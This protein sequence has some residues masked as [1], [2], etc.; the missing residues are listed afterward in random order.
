MKLLELAHEVGI[1]VKK[2]SNGKGGE[3]HCACPSCGEGIDRFMIWP[4]INRYW[5]RRCDAN[6]D[7]IQFCRDFLN[8]TF[9]ESCQRVG[10][11][12]CTYE[13]PQVEH[14]I[15]ESFV[16]AQQPPKA[17]QEKA[18]AYVEWAHKQL[19][20]SLVTLNELHKRGFESQTISRYK[21]GHSINAD[22]SSGPDFFRERSKWGLPPEYRANGTSRKLWLPSGLVIPSFS[23][24]GSIYKLKVRRE[25]W[26]SQDQLPK[27]VE[28]SGSK[29]CPSFYG[30]ASCQVAI[31]L[32]AELD[33]M[34]IQQ[35]AGNLCCC[36]ALGGATK[37][38]DG[39][40]DVL[41]ASCS[42]ILWCLDN[43]E[44]GKKAALWWRERYPHLRFWPAE[45]GKSPG[46]DF[47]DHGVNLREW[48]L[49]G[50]AYHSQSN[51]SAK[52]INGTLQ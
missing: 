40:I 16:T 39:A 41:L 47:K 32:E 19:E 37:K 5:C 29:L 48:I 14:V 9:L 17:W 6:G 13:H 52:S 28:I 27:Y 50:I 49:R 43:D 15:K 51:K 44:A 35:E 31:V 24:D 7:S 22:S 42:L 30:D 46:D 36:I 11:T 10:E 33:A 45:I 8:M 3:Y 26:N 20:L 25:R 21:L 34:L 12:A 18:L 23:H 38:P 1:E 4:A 2:T